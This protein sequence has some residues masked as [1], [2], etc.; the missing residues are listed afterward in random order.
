MGITDLLKKP[1]EE[2][3][4]ENE[5]LANLESDALFFAEQ[6]PNSL[7]R[8]KVASI[9]KE[10]NKVTINKV[11]ISDTLVMDDFVMLLVDTTRLPFGLRIKDLC[12]PETLKTLGGAC[13]T[14]VDYEY[15]E[16][17]GFWYIIE[18][19][20]GYGAIPRIIKYQEALELAPKMD[21]WEFIIGV[22]ANKRVITA[23][24]R[25]TPNLV[26][27]GSV[28]AGKTVELKQII[29]SLCEKNSPKALR[30]VVT[31][32]KDGVDF[33]T[34]E[35]LPHL[36]TPTA[37]SREK[38]PSIN[39]AGEMVDIV[40]EDCADRIITEPDELLAV[41]RYARKEVHRRNK[42]LAK[43]KEANNIDEWNA[44]FRFRRF[45]RIMICID[46]IAV[47]MLELPKSESKEIENLLSGIARLGRAPGI[48]LFFGTQSVTSEI[49]T[50]SI[51]HNFTARIAGYCATGP[52]SGLALGTGSYAATRIDPIAGRGVWRDGLN[53][54][55]MQ[56]PYLGPKAVVEMLEAVRTKWAEPETPLEIKL[57]AWALEHNQGRFAIDEV[58]EAHRDTV[59]VEQV[60]DIAEANE[61]H[62]DDDKK[63][64]IPG[65]DGFY[66]LL[67]EI[68]GKLPR[69][70]VSDGKLHAEEPDTPKYDLTF[71][72]VAEYSYY[73]FAG[74]CAMSKL[75]PYFKG[76]ISRDAL[77]A[78]LKTNEGKQIT[79]A[80]N[81]MELYPS[82]GGSSPRRLGP[83][84]YH[85][86]GSR[87]P[88]SDL[89]NSTDRVGA[90]N[91]TDN[92]N[93]PEL[94]IPDWLATEETE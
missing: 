2:E 35:S 78:M 29:L 70:L 31:D 69:R 50:A 75:Y 6:I 17:S 26:M 92:D 94:E 89:E 21:K 55:E 54:I 87:L 56:M 25:R 18:R 41:L 71:R 85:V 11:K 81:D 20:S 33:K 40:T 57:F 39:D 68:P 23:D 52:Q 61:F 82:L 79:I 83:A 36:G 73:N 48:H 34:L 28:G 91:E 67:P 46:E 7:A 58:Y 63:F 72:E 32:F 19:K 1:T 66:V 27:A 4:A 59:T 77:E 42:I 80:G 86:P 8:M 10:K 60:R 76:K 45:P 88:D 65:Y 12:D 62:G 64:E 47:A 30:V 93:E 90:E 43:A 16:R 3:L 53:E 37:I 84:Q 13:R 49:L 24:L 38:T 5:R 15:N 74:S 14:P 44:Q 9:S 51:N 22:G